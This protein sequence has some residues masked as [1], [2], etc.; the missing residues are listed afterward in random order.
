LYPNADHYGDGALDVTNVTVADAPVTVETSIQDTVLRV[1]LDSVFPSGLPNT[2]RVSITM[3]MAVTVPAN[4]TGSYGIFSY[5]TGSNTWV[6]ADWP[7]V[8][9]AYEADEG[10]QLDPPLGT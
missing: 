9:A 10:W 7:P 3:D 1:P 2:A 6:L 5:A 8:L 4:S